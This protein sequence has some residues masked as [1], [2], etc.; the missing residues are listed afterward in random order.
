MKASL[1]LDASAAVK[2]FVEESGAMRGVRDLYL[3]GELTSTCPH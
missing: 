2:W 1:V 3:R